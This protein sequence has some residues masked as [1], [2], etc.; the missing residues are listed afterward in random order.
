MKEEKEIQILLKETLLEVEAEAEAK[1]GVKVGVEIGTK[2]EIEMILKNM[3][4]IKKE[5]NLD[6]WIIE[7]GAIVGKNIMK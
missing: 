2:V 5:I 4:G 3:I 7:A 6:K 1:V